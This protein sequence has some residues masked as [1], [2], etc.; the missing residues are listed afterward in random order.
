MRAKYG[1]Y[2]GSAYFL[3]GDV[4]EAV[5]VAGADPLQQLLRVVVVLLELSAR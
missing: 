5:H 1:S 4:A 3:V 2:F